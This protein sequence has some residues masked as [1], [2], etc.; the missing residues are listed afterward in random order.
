MIK[1]IHYTEIDIEIP[2]HNVDMMEVDWHIVYPLYF[3]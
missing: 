1:G 3:T 2:S